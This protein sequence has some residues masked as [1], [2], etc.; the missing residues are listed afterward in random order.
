MAKKKPAI[1]APARW[2]GYGG[3]I[4]FYAPVL[5]LWIRVPGYE[6]AAL[7]LLFAYASVILSFL[8]AVHWG[9]ALAGDSVNPDWQRL[10]WSVVP[11]LLGWGLTLLP[12]LR[13][14]ILGFAIAFALA[15]FVDGKAVRD[16][17]FPAWY[18]RLRKH[19]TAG[20][21]IALILTL[22]AGITPIAL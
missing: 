8:G 9:R 20:V 11:A 22:L 17:I 13:L 21:E 5:A 15:Y 2:L 6:L 19:L 7:Q 10:G 1:P 12:D 4:P 16:G 14:V 3:L 18:G